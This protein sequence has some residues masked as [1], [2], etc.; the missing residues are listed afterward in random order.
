M[1]SR[2]PELDTPQFHLSEQIL[3]KKAE[4]GIEQELMAK[5]AKVSLD[6]YVSFEMASTDFTE[7]QYEEVLERL[8]EYT[9]KGEGEA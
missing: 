2:F 5:I 4:L 3:S 8:A 7:S 1:L 6:D 9:L